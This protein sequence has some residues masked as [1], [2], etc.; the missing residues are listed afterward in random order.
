MAFG[1]GKVFVFANPHISIIYVKPELEGETEVEELLIR[2][3]EIE[4]DIKDNPHFAT[5][6][7]DRK[8]K[9][10]FEVCALTFHAKEDRLYILTVSEFLLCYKV[11]LVNDKLTAIYSSFRALG[12][13]LEQLNHLTH[14]RSEVESTIMRVHGGV[15]LTVRRKDMVVILDV[16]RCFRLY[17]WR[18]G[19][20]ISNHDR[21]VGAVPK[22]YTLEGTAQRRREPIP[23]AR[24]IEYQQHSEVIEAIKRHHIEVEGEKGR[25]RQRQ[26]EDER[27]RHMKGIKEA[28]EV[29]DKAKRLKE[30]ES[31]L[32]WEALRK[33]DDRAAREIGIGDDADDDVDDDDDDD[34]DHSKS[35]FSQESSNYKMPSPN[36]LEERVSSRG[37][38]LQPSHTSQTDSHK[39]T[40]SPSLSSGTSLDSTP[41]TPRSLQHGVESRESS[42]N[43]SDRA[44]SQ[45]SNRALSVRS[46]PST[47]SR[48][49]SQS[50][51]SSNAET[52]DAGPPAGRRYGD[53]P[54]SPEDARS[55]KTKRTRSSSAGSSG[56]SGGSK[57]GHPKSSRPRNS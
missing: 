49:R 3:E 10:P 43:N 47:S 52:D 15:F 29:E 41:K 14:S 42:Q 22:M 18:S 34:D 24:R 53:R 5:W 1:G 37:V 45:S 46:K 31:K 36:A 50:P 54:L 56:T 30:R 32:R 21:N 25:Y 20:D 8:S 44:G 40:S 26:E 19:F 12:L 23:E 13:E 9:H 7:Q 2:E 35:S 57:V 16:I 17:G 39:A 11:V 33:L 55:R 38:S 6:E 27:Q 4:V 28:K 51:S 48:E